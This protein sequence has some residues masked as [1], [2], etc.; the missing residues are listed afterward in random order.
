MVDVP[1]R[2]DVHVRLR[3]IE[4]LLRH[5]LLSVSSRRP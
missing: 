3:P 2:P 1:N 5:G 4:L